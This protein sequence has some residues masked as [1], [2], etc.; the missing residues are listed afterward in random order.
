LLIPVHLGARS[1]TIVVQRGAL[2][3]VGM[4]LRALGVGGR[5]ALFT[6]KTIGRLYGK[7]VVES[8]TAAG[9]AVTTVELPDGEQAKTLTI[10]S[11]GWDACVAARLDRSS[12]ILAL[13]GGAVGDLAGFVSA[14]YMRGTNFVQLP[15]TVLA[16]VD[17]SSGGKT[18]IDHPKGKNMIGAFHQPRLVIVDTATADSLPAREYRSGLA[19]VVKH[20]IVLDASYFEDVEASA[21]ALGAR[22]PVAVDRIIAGSCRLKASVIERDERESALRM[23]LNYGHTIGHAIEAATGFEQLTHGEA[24]ALGMVAEAAL[25]VRLGVA[26]HATRE[27]Q[28][29]VLAHLELPTRLPSVDPERVLDAMTHDKKGRDGRVPFVLAPEIGQFKI[30]EAVSAEDVRA[31]LAEITTRR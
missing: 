18:A 19:E 24:V 3:T 31:A 30:V 10:A 8:L 4:Q 14:T 22:E 2:A 11:Q 7:A 6:D 1:Y 17:A 20:G 27:R 25:A 16:Q 29:R 15:T 13:G 23:V 9:F 21:D 5:A 12:T 28:E 26:Q